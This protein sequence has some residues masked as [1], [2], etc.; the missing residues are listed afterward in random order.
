[1]ISLT[2][3]EL[4]ER[5]PTVCTFPGSEVD[6]PER[7]KR[8]THPID[9]FLAEHWPIPKCSSPSAAVGEAILN[10]IEH[11]NREDPRKRVWVYMLRLDDAMYLAVRDE[12]SG[13]DFKEEHKRCLELPSHVTDETGRNQGLF[14]MCS[15]F[16]DVYNF[17]ENIIYLAQHI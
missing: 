17:G 14:V 8:I 11:G 12:G 1:M 5:K 15:T 16:D 4:L 9:R 13:F 6:T 3:K 10:A 2:L 7:Y